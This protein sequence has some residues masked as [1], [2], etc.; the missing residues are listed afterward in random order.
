MKI[1]ASVALVTGSNRGLGKACVAILLERGAA[2]VY[3]AARNATSLA[4]VVALDPGRVVA[5]ELDVTRPETIERAAAQATDVDLLINNAGT[6]A[7]FSVLESGFAALH[8]DMHANYFGPLEVA[9][10]FV[11]VLARRPQSAIVNVLSVVSLSSMPGIGG[12]SASKAA[13]FSLTQSLRAELAAKDISVHAVFPGPIDTDMIRT[14]DLPKTHPNDVARAML[15]GIAAGEVDIFP[16]A[17][18]KDVSVVWC[19]DPRAIEQ[20]FARG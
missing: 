14:F 9:R 5:I 1:E 6:L 12:Y 11:P 13:A 18:S 4:P 16:D 20:R 8:A 10:R 17:M 3:A 15:D 19:R 7:S 2:R